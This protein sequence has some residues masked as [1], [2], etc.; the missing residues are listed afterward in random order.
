[1]VPG[2][3]EEEEPGRGGHPSN[4][5]GPGL[6][7]TEGSGACWDVVSHLKTFCLSQMFLA[8][9]VLCWWCFGETEVRVVESHRMSGDQ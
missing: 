8:P 1:M 2:R 6:V 3:R 4:T 5:A 7:K 9:R